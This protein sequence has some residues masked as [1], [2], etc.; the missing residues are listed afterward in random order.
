MTGPPFLNVVVK[1]S[2]VARRSRYRGRTRMLRNLGADLASTTTWS[3]V[4]TELHTEITEVIERTPRVHQLPDHW[5]IY[6]SVVDRTRPVR[7]LEIGGF[8]GDSLEKWQEFL[9]P[10]S[11]VVGVDVDSKLVKIANPDGVRV[12]LADGQARALLSDVAYEFGPFDVIVDVGSQA[13]HHMTESFRCLFDTALTADGAYIVEDVYCDFWTLYNGF[14]F[15]GLVR[16]VAD[17]LY[18]H[19]EFATSPAHF[20]DGHVV[21]IRRTRAFARDA[22]GGRVTVRNNSRRRDLPR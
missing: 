2:P 1:F 14:T 12:R 11:L 22:S 8:Y 7:L 5:R 21:V 18:G 15:V 4:D 20:K 3:A 6:E 10:D 19:Y 16:A 9:H 13:C 17:V